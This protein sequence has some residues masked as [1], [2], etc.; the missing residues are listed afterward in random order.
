MG[1]RNIRGRRKKRKIKKRHEGG[2]GTGIG[3]TSKPWKVGAKMN[4]E[5][6]LEGQG[7]LWGEAHSYFEKQEKKK[8]HKRALWKE[9]PIPTKTEARGNGFEIK[10]F[11]EKPKGLGTGRFNEKRKERK[12]WGILLNRSGEHPLN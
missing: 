3:R 1:G 9:R 6:L 10:Q 2:Q 8:M 4:D 12:R 7:I 11:Y 5:N